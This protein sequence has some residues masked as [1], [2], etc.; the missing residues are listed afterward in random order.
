M[1]NKDYNSKDFK[2]P[3]LEKSAF[4]FKNRLFKRELLE[5]IENTLR[6][7]KVICLEC[8]KITIVTWPINTINFI[9]Y[10][11]N[12]YLNIYSNILEKE[13]NNNN[14]NNSR[15]DSENNI[16][17][18]YSSSNLTSFFSSNLRK[19]PSYL[20]FNKDNYKELL[21]NFIIANN[22]SFSILNSIY[23]NNLLKYLKDDLLI[24]SRKSIKNYL[25]ILYNSEF[26]KIRNKLSKNKAKF[27]I[28]LDK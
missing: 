1:S 24:I 10:F 18:S 11:K 5:P 7:V 3:P 17:I 8:N 4:I 22:L 28:T 2:M 21:L 25:D 15:E 13:N 26:N 20:L 12:K 16:N 19:R 9:N 14:I 6:K 23:F 27:S